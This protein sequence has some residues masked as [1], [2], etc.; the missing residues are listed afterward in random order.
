MRIMTALVRCASI[1]TL[2]ALFS[3][4]GKSTLP[5]EPTA[6]FGS[7]VPTETAGSFGFPPVSGTTRV[8]LATTAPSFSLLEGTSRFVLYDDSTF[9]LQYSHLA[10]GGYGGTYE[11]A[12]DG[13]VTFR[14][15]GW[16][17]GGPWGSTG[18]LTGNTLTVRY[19]VIMGLTDF[20]DGV[21]TRVR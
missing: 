19:N 21:Y 8:Y 7:S 10:N 9:V 4:C 6:T 11:V 20:D 14:W 1:V 15:H 12:N 17:R 2:L 18:T 16:S 3:A 5:T 13:G